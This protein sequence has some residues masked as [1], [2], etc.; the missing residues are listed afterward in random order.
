M[1]KIKFQVSE[2]S[3]LEPQV[4]I[5]KMLLVLKKQ[6]YIIE[7]TT[8]NIISFR[9][10][11]WEMRSKNAV[12]RK[13]DKGVFEV[14]PTNEGSLIKYIYYV[15]FL[16]EII[17]TTIILVGFFALSHLVLLIALPLWIQLGVRIYTLKDVSE[18]MLKRLAV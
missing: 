3:L 9:D 10:D 12:F 18:Q 1:M 16:P 11:N 17:I 13:V 7:N 14:A 6:N 2:T 5:D 8:S 15:S 4:L